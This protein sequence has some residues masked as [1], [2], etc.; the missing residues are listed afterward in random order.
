MVKPYSEDL[1][2][3]VVGRVGSGDTVRDVAAIFDVSVASVVRWSQR[4]FAKL[5]RAGLKVQAQPLA[6]VPM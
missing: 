6:S 3:R 1:R 5:D 4:F 2:W